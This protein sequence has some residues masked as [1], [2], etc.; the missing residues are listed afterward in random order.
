MNYLLCDTDL[1][2]Y[3]RRTNTASL[4]CTRDGQH[5]PAMLE[6]LPLVSSN[7]SLTNC[8]THTDNSRETTV[9]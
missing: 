3:V 2:H 8:N 7:L 4:H 5:F 9:Y 1:N 6:R